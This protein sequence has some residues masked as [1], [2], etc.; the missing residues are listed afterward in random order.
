MDKLEKE[1]T[2]EKAR[3][4]VKQKQEGREM[5]YN[6]KRG[7]EKGKRNRGAEIKV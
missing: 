6:R 4:R 2:E 5:R 3:L 1:D 7:V